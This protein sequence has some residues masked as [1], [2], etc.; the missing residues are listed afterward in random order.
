MG[1]PMTSQEVFDTVAKHLFG[2]GRP[3]AKLDEFGD[4]DGCFYRS[5]DGLKCAIGAL[6]PDDQYDPEFEGSAASTIA[7]AIPSL[8][9]VSS[10]LLD[11]LQGVHDSGEPWRSTEA[12]RKALRDVAK[13]CK[14]KTAILS[15]LS[16]NRP[17]P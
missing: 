11:C 5:A 12:M 3:A 9:G 1:N 14:V 17:T 4:P 7:H 6:I 10:S 16:F 13:D 8:H 15:D 2:Q